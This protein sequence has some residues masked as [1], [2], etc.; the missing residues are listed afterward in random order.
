MK[1]VI[2]GAGGQLGSDL[3][4][5]LAEH[6]PVAASRTLFDIERPSAIAK[7]LAQYEPELVINTA[8]FHNVE[9][10]ETRPDRAMAVNGLAVDALAMQCASAGAAFAH[11]STD[12]VFD[13][14]TDRPYRETDAA[15]PINAYGISKLAGE[16]FVR[17]S[18]AKHF[19]FRTSG[20]YGVRGS[21]TK[22]YTFI[23]RM[24]EGA[25]AGKPLRVV[26]D[27][28]FSPSY[29]RHVARAIA[30]VVTTD[31]YGTYHVTNAGS[32]T[33]FDFA[34]EIFRQAGLEPEL[35]RTT[36]AAFPSLVRRP[37][38]S[39]LAHAALDAL[40]LAAGMPSWRDG[41]RDYLIERRFAKP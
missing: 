16:L 33:W 39:A 2:V 18:A 17:R 11:V 32:C 21:S 8:A 27:V 7:L 5:A 34:S 6:A 29:T 20:L 26:D 38:Y 22:G 19:V 23:E 4:D 13:G 30:N 24:L 25:A 14:E 40:G 37:R 15:N 10:C 12:Y 9:L 28:T 31:A 36:Q 41:I 3:V 1:I 35:S